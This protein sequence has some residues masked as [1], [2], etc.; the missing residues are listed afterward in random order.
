[1]KCENWDIYDLF[2][3]KLI[4]LQNTSLSNLLVV[5]LFPNIHD[6]ALYRKKC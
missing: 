1:M 3:L 4:F 5:M 6:D 2:K